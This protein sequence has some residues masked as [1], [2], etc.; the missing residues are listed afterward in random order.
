M[1]GI[2]HK[3]I[4]AQNWI[5]KQYGEEDYKR[6]TDHM[7]ERT[8]NN[9]AILAYMTTDNSLPANVRLIALATMGELS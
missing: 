1:Y 2:A 8:K 9:I 7:K 3:I 5:K 6:I 4:E